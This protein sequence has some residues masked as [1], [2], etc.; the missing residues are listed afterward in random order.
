MF[1]FVQGKKGA[2]AE[3]TDIFEDMLEMDRIMWLMQ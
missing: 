3:Y 1:W 2:I